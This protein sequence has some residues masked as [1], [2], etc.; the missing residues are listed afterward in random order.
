MAEKTKVLLVEVLPKVA[1]KLR[2]MLKPEY[3]FY[4][5]VIKYYNRTYL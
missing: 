1:Q 2:E 5:K 3:D 4:E